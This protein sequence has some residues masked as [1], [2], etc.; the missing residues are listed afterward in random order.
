MEKFFKLSE[1]GTNVRTEVIAG[2]TTFMA[3]A[4]ILMVNPGMFSELGVPFGANYIAT[5]LSAVVGTVLIG[6]L[7]NLPLAQASGMGL[8]AFF[9]YTACFGLGFSYANALL[10][11]LAD[12]IIFILL[13]LTGLRRII[14]EAVP[15]AVKAAI[16]A[17]IGLFIAFLGL[18]NSGIVVKDPATGVNLAS[19]NLL[20]SATWGSIMPLLITIFAIIAIAVM[21]KKGVKGAIL[22]SV[23]GA[24]VLY[25]VLGFTVPGF[26]DGFL[27]GVSLNPITAF[28]EFGTESFFK[29][30]TEGFDFSGYLS[31]EGNDVASLIIAFITTALAFCMVD[32]FDTMGTLY[33]ACRGGGLLVKNEKG[34]DEVPNMDKA[35]LADAIATCTGAVFGTSTVTTYVESASGVGAGGRTGL[36]SMVTAALFFVA[37]FLS[38]I[39]AL[40]PACAYAAALVYVGILM[41]ACV[42]DIDWADP[43]IA[44]PSFLTIAMMPFTYN[45]S[46]GIAFGLI[47]HIIVKIGTGKIKEINVGTWV[48]ALL[49]TA[50][51]F[52]TH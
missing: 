28:K 41:I 50:M 19:F 39:A 29:V 52:L 30:F 32:M 9:V 25:Y 17:G 47:S 35:M 46:Y 26:Y 16:P 43:A 34:E 33:G 37:M 20:G 13:T 6:L 2:I 22:W 31:K 44:L 5:A 4:Y 7:A 23:L 8:N 14:F 42:K 21:S 38:P 49:F 1:R 40:I 11:V 10:F 45:I 51:F 3:M 18:Q 24:A 12:G 48:I 15:A 36:S 27:D